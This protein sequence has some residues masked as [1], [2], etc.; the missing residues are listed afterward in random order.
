MIKDLDIA[1]GAISCHAMAICIC[2]YANAAHMLKYNEISI[3]ES[4]FIAYGS[5]LPH[6]SPP[7]CCVVA[8]AVDGAVGAVAGS[9]NGPG[10]VTRH[11]A[12]LF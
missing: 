2:C 12:K 9:R 8:L 11:R 7:G 1:I 5:T 3:C 6:S 10:G 4:P